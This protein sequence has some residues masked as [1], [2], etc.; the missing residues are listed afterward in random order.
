MSQAIVAFNPKQ[1]PA[2]AK[3]RTTPSALSKALAGSGGGGYPHKLSIKGGVFRL[4][5]AGKEIASIEERYLDVVFIGASEKVGRIYYGAKF[6][7]TETAAPKCQSTD[8][9]KP[10][11]NVPEKQSET[12][13]NCP[14]N[15]KGSGDG[16][17]K[18]CRYWQRVA[19]G[20][21]NDL[22]GNILQLT[23][24]SKSIFGKEE[25]GNFP[26]QAYARWLDAQGI[27]PDIV[28]TRIRFDT[29]ESA[30][31]LF[32]RV[33]RYLTD[34]EFASVEKLAAS[35]AAKSA[36]DNTQEGVEPVVVAEEPKG[37][38]FPPDD[39]DAPPPVAPKPRKPKAKPV[40]EDEDD[41]APE[42]TVRKTKPA[43]EAKPASSVASIVTDW[44]T[45]D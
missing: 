20:L 28:V 14:M 35:P 43:A 41:V 11:A 29:R 25:G 26:L 45:D 38:Q 9:V 13:A 27:D 15:I 23:V 44:D 3:K 19:L 12:C 22:D 30:P 34:D 5:A 36:I 31:K 32:F 2:F 37:P 39:D 18:A 16:D 7:E 40:A 10:D 4:L 21:A 6:S 8:G 17:T 24:P 42:P 1:L 33:E